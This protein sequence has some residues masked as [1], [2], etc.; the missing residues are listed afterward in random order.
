[1]LY[2]SNFFRNVRADVDLFRFPRFPPRMIALSSHDQTSR[3]NLT[4]GPL[5]VPVESFRCVLREDWCHST[6]LVHDVL[7]VK[8]SFSPYFWRS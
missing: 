5:P 7:L 4:V 3:V 1:M 2:L 8:D 6:A